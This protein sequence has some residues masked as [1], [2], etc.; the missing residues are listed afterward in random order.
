MTKNKA[1]NMLY[2]APPDRIAYICGSCQGTIIERAIKRYA[3]KIENATENAFDN[4]RT[5]NQV[6]KT[7]HR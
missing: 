6:I 7:L 5:L 2:N 3:T 4:C 1:L